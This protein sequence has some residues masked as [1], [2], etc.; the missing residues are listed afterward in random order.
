MSDHGKHNKSPGFKS[1][2]NWTTCQRCG[3]DVYGSDIRKE[4]TG[5]LVCSSCWEPRH[6]QDFV[7]AIKEDTSAKGFVTGEITP[8]DVERT[9]VLDLGKATITYTAHDIDIIDAPPDITNLNV[10]SVGYTDSTN[11]TSLV[12][13][14]VGYF[15]G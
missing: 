6:P 7:R 1:G 11:I 2:D 8:E 3:F 15:T 4:W 5:S 12:L 10:P 13:R 9:L 14:G